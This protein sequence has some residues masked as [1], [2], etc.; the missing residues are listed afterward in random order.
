LVSEDVGVL[1]VDARQNDYIVEVG[2]DGEYCRLLALG[3]WLCGPD[4][5][6]GQAG[7]GPWCFT[8]A[9]RALQLEVRYAARDRLREALSDVRRAGGPAKASLRS[10]FFWHCV[11][12]GT[13]HFCFH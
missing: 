1:Y 7:R 10:L 8:V 12:L 5:V 2:S 4:A 6:R 13:L 3:T 11:W 9:S